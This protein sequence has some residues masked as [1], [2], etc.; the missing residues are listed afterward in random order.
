MQNSP[1]RKL[2]EASVGFDNVAFDDDDGRRVVGTV[3]GIN[4]DETVVT[5][6]NPYFD[7]AWQVPVEEAT[8]TDEPMTQPLDD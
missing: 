7:A 4:D 3:I 1:N 5:V 8:I 6:G 2:T